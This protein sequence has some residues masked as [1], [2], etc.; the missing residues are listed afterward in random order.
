MNGG[1]IAAMS[2]TRTP[3]PES[4]GSTATPVT[5]TA[6]VSPASALHVG[7]LWGHHSIASTAAAVVDALRATNLLAAMRP[8]AMHAPLRWHWLTL[9]GS[10][11]DEGAAPVPIPTLPEAVEPG[12]PAA[13]RNTVSL[14]NGGTT[15]P[16][17][18]GHPAVLDV[19]V[20]PGWLVATGPQLR[21]VS[22]E[23]RAHWAPLLQA[24]VA[25]G[26]R[27][28][29]V[30]NGSSLLADSGLLVGRRA[31][32]P[33]VFAPSI[34]LQS[35][36]SGQGA[37]ATEPL[38]DVLWQRDRPWQ[39]DGLLWTTASLQETTAALLDLLGQTALAELAQAASHVLLF[40]A[41][42]QLTAPS[43]METP[44]GA[45]LGAGSLEQARR[46]LQDHRNEPYSLEATARAAATSPRTLLRWFAQVYGQSPQDYLHS[47]RIAQAQ[48]LLQ[49]TYLTVEDVARQCGYGDTGSFRKVFARWCGV[50]P[51]AYRQR[52]KLRTTRKQWLE[53]TEPGR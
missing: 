41:K 7:I 25:R 15:P 31:A 16:H 1:K 46:W 23:H 51:G 34:V 8:G 10:L 32:L 27:V 9:P 14:G 30:F 24:H 11:Q 36:Q 26:G 44:T 3:P 13:P 21:E 2:A 12:E 5:P 17:S 18:K 37:G 43:A 28:L 53:R 52:F 38:A 48:T 49:T 6:S 45:P 4:A 40:D 35:Q 39:R 47:L 42:R 20:L 33:W 50:T 19:I 22:R 29:A